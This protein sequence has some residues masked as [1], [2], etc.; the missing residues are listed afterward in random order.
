MKTANL[1]WS[2]NLRF[3][4]NRRQLSQ[5]QLAEDL[6]ISRAKLNAHE[7]GLS[8]NP[9]LED[10]IRFADYFKMSLDTLLR[11]NLSRLGELK[12]RELEAGNDVYLTGRQIRVLAT[13]V[14]KQNNENVEL[15][16]IKAKAGYLA[17]YNDPQFISKL[18]RFSI[19]DLPSGKT[20]RLF[21]IKGESML[22]VPEDSIVIAS[23]IQ[24]MLA[25]KKDT[26]C[27]VVVKG[28]DIAFKLVDISHVQMTGKMWLKSLN[29][30]FAPYEVDVADVLEVWQFYGYLSKTIPEEMNNADIV[31]ALNHLQTGMQE[32][33]KRG[34]EE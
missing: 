4:R 27:I 1:F 26:P 30:R 16:P 2:E 34:L 9:P 29:V 14:D 22:P 3:L 12:V 15:V 10:L 19:P 33:L 23:Y 13:T 7:N 21:P 18:P 17:G 24:D 8:R 25:I 11:I 6:K 5:N 28:Q 32:L 20:Y 31:S